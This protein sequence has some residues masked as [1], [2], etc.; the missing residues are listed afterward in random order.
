MLI[1]SCHAD[2]GFETHYLEKRD[3]GT[4]YGNLDNFVGVHAVMEAYF[5]GRL[6]RDYLRVEL[7]YDEEKDFSGACEVLETVK[8]TDVVVVVDVTG[9]VTTA[10]VHVEKCQNRAVWEFLE[11]ALAGLNF[12]MYEHCD[13]PVSDQDETDVYIK[14][15]Q[16]VFF[17]GVPCTGGDYNDGYVSCRRA[18]IDATREAVCRIVEGYPA[19]CE[20]EGLPLE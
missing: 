8:S 1:F 10:D 20:K 11:T 5:S 18:N 15:S 7:T 3:D 2:T 12:R 4:Y 6:N 16:Y 9:A 14:K 19:F 17:L 13:D